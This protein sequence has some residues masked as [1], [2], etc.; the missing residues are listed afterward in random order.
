MTTLA[1]QTLDRVGDRAVW[2][3]TPRCMVAS[4]LFASLLG[5]TCGGGPDT[6]KDANAAGGGASKTAGA[7]VSTA[8][9]GA[10]STA[11]RSGAGGSSS[12]G[13]SGAAGSAGQA[14]SGSVFCGGFAARPC[15]GA[16]Q[17][18]DDPSD[19]CDPRAG[20]ADCGG[21]CQCPKAASTPCPTGPWNADP[22]TCACMA[23]SVDAGMSSSAWYTS[24]GSPVC[25]DTGGPFDDPAIP[26]CTM[27]QREGGACATVGERCDGVASCGATLVCAQSD[28]KAQPGGCPIS[29]ALF[30]RDIAYLDQRDLRSVR[31][32]LM[33]IPLATYVYRDALTAGPQLGFLIDDIEPSVAAS[34]DRVNLYGYLSMA[35]AAIQV[36]QKQ[37]EALEREVRALRARGHASAGARSTSL[38]PATR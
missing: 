10:A 16:G 36:Q 37:I 29:R 19:S 24:C 20:G 17:C 26:N 12:G 8:G 7:G 35:V 5:A 1:A 27:T 15:P 14:G 30:K 33:R 6:A 13:T 31:D 38:G 4:A 32:D 11:G 9:G 18:V 22:H 34:D 28:P 3:R 2:R 25:R 23:G 21:I